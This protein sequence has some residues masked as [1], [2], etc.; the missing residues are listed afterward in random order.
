[1]F[2]SR[3]FPGTPITLIYHAT[4]KFFPIV[5]SVAQM[6]LPFYTIYGIRKILLPTKETKWIN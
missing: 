4:G 5:M 6:T 1:M 2:I 3:D